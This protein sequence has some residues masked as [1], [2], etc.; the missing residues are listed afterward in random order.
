[1]RRIILFILLSV[2]SATGFAK[3]SVSLDRTT[4]D[5]DQTVNLTISSDEQI[6][7]QPNL[8]GLKKDFSILGTS[9]NAQLTIINGNSQ[10][11]QQW[12]ITLIPLHTGKV[13]IPAITIGKETTTSLALTIKANSPATISSKNAI[14]LTANIEPVTAYVN[15][16]VLYIVKL[17]YR[18]ESIS[19]SL[20][21]PGFGTLAFTRVGNDLNYQV[22]TNGKR[23][24]VLERRYVFF[25]QKSG[26]LSLP[27][28]VF[29]GEVPT[30]SSRN[31][32]L[33][34]LLQFTG[35]RPIQVRAPAVIL[36]VKA[37]P[38]TVDADSWVPAKDFSAKEIWSS[39]L[40][41]IHVGDP[42]TRTI[43][44]RA[45]GLPGNQ[46]PDIASANVM[47]TNVYPSP[48][49]IDTD[50]DG[51]N[52]IG[53]KIIKIAYIPTQATTIVLPAITLKWFDISKGRL[54]STTLPAQTVHIHPAANEIHI[55][56]TS[57]STAALPLMPLNKP[58]AAVDT[59][60]LPS[61]IWPWIAASLA[62]LWVLTLLFG[63][64]QRQRRHMAHSSVEQPQ[65]EKPKNARQ[66]IR[67]AC[68]TNDAKALSQALILWAQKQ[69]PQQKIRHLGDV[70]Q[71]SMS[72]TLKQAIRNLE[73]LLYKNQSNICDG[74]QFWLLFA[75]NE[76]IK[77]T[78]TKVA[79]SDLPSLYPED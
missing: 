61:T 3:L 50:T 17:F 9:K 29:N 16:Q 25:P 74:H 70:A 69:W 20:S 40:T 51:N 53:S 28:V 15:S 5:L 13:T 31:D 63:W 21:E 36:T 7:D 45:V 65:K 54:I 39:N 1:M 24:N 62:L 27:G 41:T 26:Q 49:K 59:S 52:I 43:V 12:I 48:A 23:Y 58:A 75:Q 77:S 47:N 76:K 67:H 71:Q 68:N 46:L 55:S 10:R 34:E 60:K 66:M 78:P 6:D 72:K 14:F 33:N 11:L 19:G 73:P 35:T 64:W 32:S 2:I 22:T 4:I 44:L 42:I 37:K 57:S 18:N 79:N 56:N 30:H 8:D 38:A